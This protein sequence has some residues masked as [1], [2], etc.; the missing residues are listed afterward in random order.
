MSA[1]ANA[2]C[3]WHV[4]PPSTEGRDKYTG[5]GPRRRILLDRGNLRVLNRIF[6]LSRD[7]AD[8]FAPLQE[9]PA[10]ATA[11]GDLVFRGADRLFGA[12]AGLDPHQ[13][14]FAR[15]R[16]E[17]KHPVL[18]RLKLDQDDTL[19]WTGEEVDLV[20]GTQDGARLLRGRD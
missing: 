10:L 2:T 12:A 9:L 11:A 13:V 18:P 20:G 4:L 6:D 14:T 5:D 17:T 19:A 15:G 3:P 7:H 16:N 8:E 1:V